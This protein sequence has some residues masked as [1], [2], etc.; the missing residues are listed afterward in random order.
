MTYFP[1]TAGG[2]PI[3]A[4][5][6]AGALALTDRGIVTRGGSDYSAPL[7]ALAT[8][9]R[10]TQAGSRI[11]ALPATLTATDHDSNV[12]L[13][14]TGGTLGIEAT[15]TDGFRCHVVNAASGGV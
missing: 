11:A 7:S 9:S 15:V 13:T 1:D 12:V 5:P 6:D 2:Q 10:R 14:G 8:L 3:A 4:F